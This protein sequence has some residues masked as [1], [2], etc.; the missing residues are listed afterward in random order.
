MPIDLLQLVGIQPGAVA[1]ALVQNDPGAAA[2]VAAQHEVAAFGAAAVLQLLAHRVGAR[3]SRWIGAGL[4]LGV[5]MLVDNAI[6]VLES[7]F[8][9]RE[10]GASAFEAAR[11]GASEVGRAVIASTL[12]TVAASP[13][14]IVTVP[15]A[16]I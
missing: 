14:G 2:V 8:R 4:A 12:T 11:L 1:P 9:R 6:V 3:H 15:L 5:G 13:S 16:A 10:Q 7:I